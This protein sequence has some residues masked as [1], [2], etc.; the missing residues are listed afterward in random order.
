M[1]RLESKIT[2][3]TTLTVSETCVSDRHVCM[4]VPLSLHVCMYYQDAMRGN[5]FPS[6]SHCQNI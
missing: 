6:M 2:E 1:E 4:C 3:P 5:G